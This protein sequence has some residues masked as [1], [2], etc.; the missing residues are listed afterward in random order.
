MTNDCPACYCVVVEKWLVAFIQIYRMVTEYVFG[1][2]IKVHKL[3][4]H[5]TKATEDNS[6]L[7]EEILKG[8]ANVPYR[9]LCFSLI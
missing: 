4:R 2:I 5:E 7:Y 8:G 9:K 6:E 3:S 1:S